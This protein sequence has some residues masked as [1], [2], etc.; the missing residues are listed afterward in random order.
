MSGFSPR[1]LA[2]FVMA[3]S[4]SQKSSKLNPPGLNSILRLRPTLRIRP[5]D[6]I[7]LAVIG[8][9]VV[10]AM[11]SPRPT[12]I[13]RPATAISIPVVETQVSSAAPDFGSLDEDIGSVVVGSWR[14]GDINPVRSLLDDR[15]LG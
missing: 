9:V 8:A 13:P 12:L 2:G 11:L 10:A 6:L 14:G 4:K 5:Q 3:S 15:P 1:T 7:A